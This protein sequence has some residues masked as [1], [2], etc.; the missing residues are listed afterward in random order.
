MG[1]RDD[2]RFEAN[3]R[4]EDVALLDAR[5]YEFNAATSG[6]DN[7]RALAIFVRDG[8]GTIV[9]GLHGWTWGGTG[10]VQTL[11]VHEKLRRSG[12]G[13][14]LLAE[15]EAE[16]RRRDCHQMHLDTHSYQA[17]GFY[18]RNGYDVIGEL[19]GWPGTDDVRIFLHK[20]LG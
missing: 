1:P 10:F 3:A 8:D 16:A 20:R 5:L 18:R 7:G 12:L 17:P 4:P 2:L 9:A 15:A 11:W 19:P 6:V 13:S 14:R